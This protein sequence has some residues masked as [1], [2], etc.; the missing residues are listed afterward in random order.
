MVTLLNKD[1]LNYCLDTVEKAL[2]A[3]STVPV[4]ENILLESDGENLFFTA[5]NLE[6]EIKVKLPCQ[7]G[8]MGKILLPSKIVEIVRYLPAPDVELNLNWDNFRVDLTSGQAK[9]SLYGLDSSD[10]PLV[11][12]VPAQGNLLKVEQGYLKQVLKAVLFAASTDETRP[13]FNGIYFSFADNAVT[14][15]ASD[16]YRLVVKSMSNQDWQF[17]QQRYLVP[18]KALRELLRILSDGEETVSIYPH[19]KQVIFNLGKVY[20]ATRVLEEKYPDVSGVI[21]TSYKTRVLMERKPFED[22]V[23]RAAL[24]AEGLNQAVQLSVRQNQLEVMVSSQV[25]RMEE[26]LPAKQE[27]DDVDVYVNSRFMM[28]ILKVAEGK[29]IIVDFHG[30]N[31]PIIFRLIN[32]QEY[33]YL[34]L[35]IKME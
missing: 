5:T 8:E 29:E 18:A 22:T 31:G 7:S 1:R 30:L 19:N 32:D 3:R 13:A 35:P 14:L 2:P 23:S 27:G 33:L 9:F 11:E 10:Y 34:V 6:M 15:N 24:L 16:T 25:G 12:E 28:D 17:E 26:A 4:I 20:F 21:P